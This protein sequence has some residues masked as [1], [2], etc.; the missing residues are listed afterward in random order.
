MAY[1]SPM[2]PDTKMNG[3][4]ACSSR[5]SA[6]AVMPSKCGMEKSDKMTCGWKSSSSRRK[7]GSV[8]TRRTSRRMPERLSSWSASSASASTSSISST[9]ICS[10]MTP[11]CRSRSVGR[12]PVHD[13]PVDAELGH[14]LDEL[15][16]LDRLDDVAVDAELVAAHD[17]VLLRAGGQHDDRDQ[18][19]PVVLAYLA[20]HLD[21]V[22]L[23]H[24]QVEQH[25]LRIAALALV[26]G[27]ATK[28]I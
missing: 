12:G 8:S 2:V 27:P 25:Q 1:S 16:E 4:S 14:F 18:A 15:V 22:H 24:L 11:T 13:G 21:P 28:K 7:S 6:S 10:L 17:V 3:M 5:A 19:G 20:Q 23:G 26:V 9:R